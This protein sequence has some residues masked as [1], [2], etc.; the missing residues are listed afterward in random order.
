MNTRVLTPHACNLSLLVTRPVKRTGINGTKGENN[1][2]N[3]LR[4]TTENGRVI[5]VKTVSPPLAPP[6][7][8]DSRMNKRK[9]VRQ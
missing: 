7:V 3:E 1:E 4:P 5:A 9:T 2:R 8:D 6:S